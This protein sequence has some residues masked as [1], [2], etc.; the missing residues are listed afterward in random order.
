MLHEEL[1]RQTARCS[2]LHFATVREREGRDCLV[3][4]TMYV[5]Q[6]YKAAETVLFCLKL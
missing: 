6:H 5:N 4:K 1:M 3:A 2:T